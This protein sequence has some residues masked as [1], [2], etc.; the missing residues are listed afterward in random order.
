MARPRPEG[1][2]ADATGPLRSAISSPSPPT[3]AIRCGSDAE[4]RVVVAVEAVAGALAPARRAGPEVDRGQIPGVV[5]VHRTRR[6]RVRVHRAGREGQLRTAVGASRRCARPGGSPCGRRR[7][8]RVRC[9]ASW[10]PRWRSPPVRCSRRCSRRPSRGR[11]RS[12]SSRSRSR[13]RRRRSDRVV[14][15]SR[16]GRGPRSVGIVPRPP[17]SD[18]R[19]SS[20]RLR[21]AL[22]RTAGPARVGVPSPHRH[23]SAPADDRARHA[24]LD[25]TS[26][27]ESVLDRGRPGR[28]AMPTVFGSASTASKPSSRRSSS[29]R[30]RRRSRTQTSSTSSS[31]SRSVPKAEKQLAMR[32][33]MARFSFHNQ[34]Q[35]PRRELP[36]TEK[37]KAGLLKSKVGGDAA[38]TP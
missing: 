9:R 4:R 22:H 29:R 11:R 20:S 38:T 15:D 30:R 19:R 36:A 31:A 17:P 14:R 7:C 33:A 5:V 21:P 18:L 2:A 35:H 34:A 25:L 6:L 27:P 24:D 1:N 8:P 28:R 26:R 23:R 13:P 10:S 3:Y 32:M 16:R 37:L 12:A